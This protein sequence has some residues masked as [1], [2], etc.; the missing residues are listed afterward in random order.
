MTGW[1]GFSLLNP[2]EWHDDRVRQPGGRQRLWLPE[3]P[4]LH[5]SETSCWCLVLKIQIYSLQHWYICL[6]SR[7]A[8]PFCTLM[9]SL[10]CKT[11]Q[12][13]SVL[14]LSFSTISPPSLVSS[15]SVKYEVIS[16]PNKALPA[17][18]LPGARSQQLWLM[19]TSTCQDVL[20][21]S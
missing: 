7:L 9:S 16:Q 8:P 12:C 20:C 3:D 11:P 17:A 14:H 10:L 15:L 6:L 19:H 1:G 21:F 2:P 5:R 13:T 18:S 4:E